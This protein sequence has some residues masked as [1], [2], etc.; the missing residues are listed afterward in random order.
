[1]VQRIERWTE[2]NIKNLTGKI[3][4][5]TGANCGVGFET[6]KALAKHHCLVVMAC[7]DLNRGKAAEMAIRDAVPD[8]EIDVMQVDLA[9]LDS[10][11]QFCTQFKN[12]YS[13]LNILINNAAVANVDY[14]F[15]KNSFEMF[16]GTNFL[17]P[18]ALTAQLYPWL[19]R[20]ED[21]RI[22]TVGSEY[23]KEVPFDF[24]CFHGEKHYSS[25]MESLKVYANS[26]M[27]IKI[28][29]F[30]MARRFN[31]S[32]VEIMS[33]VSHPG[34]AAS[35][36]SQP[37]G[38]K[39]NGLFERAATFFINHFV[40]QSAEQAALPSLR[41]ATDIFVQNGDYYGPHKEHS[42]YPV[43]IKTANHTYDAE[44]GKKLWEMAE[45]LTGIKFILHPVFEEVCVS[46]MRNK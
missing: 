2:E 4:I 11:K 38:G 5:V 21:P 33:V 19:L 14:S 37:R 6:A 29:A 10:I 13:Y 1:M 26:K 16:I 45:E 25:L 8:A 43:L 3:A 12:K 34:A 18:F 40:A 32:A 22:V 39:R 44:T 46:G 31:E 7:R 27:A 42:G 17:G 9:D 24:E 30:E 15:T 28:F 35:N 36:I 23:R 20:A 41:A